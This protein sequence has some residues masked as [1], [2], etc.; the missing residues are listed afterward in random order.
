MAKK[1]KKAVKKK[2]LRKVI[3][4]KPAKKTTKKKVVARRKVS[5]KRKAVK[6]PAKKK[7]QNVIGVVTH[8]FPKVRAAVI[9][10]KGTLTTG[11][12]IKIK[13]HTT[14]FTQG[15]TSM[16]LDHVPLS[17]AHKGQEIGLLVNSRVRQHDIVTKV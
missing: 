11:D 2:V 8:Y 7:P 5:K 15:I 17:V 6:A 13:G 16:Q 4:R 14:D 3:K 10:L 9:K 1:K 12:K